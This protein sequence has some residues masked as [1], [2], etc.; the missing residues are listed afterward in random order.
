MTLS[1][2]LLGGCGKMSF[3]IKLYVNKSS[4]NTV[5]K[6][7]SKETVLDIVLKDDTIIENPVIMLRKTETVETSLHD[8]NYCYIPRFD[9]Y[10][11]IESRESLN[12]T[13]WRLQCRVDVLMSFKTEIK[14]LHA[15][16]ERSSKWFNTYIPDDSYSVE[17]DT[18]VQTVTFPSGFTTDTML[19]VVAG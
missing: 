10:Y 19:L 6:E 11:Y 2:K 12:A 3:P 1:M 8:F 14:K 13:T 16:I 7:L 18:R 9:R 15:I 4:N 17:N 5:N